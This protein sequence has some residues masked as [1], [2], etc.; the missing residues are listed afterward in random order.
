M[1]TR[2]SVRIGLS[3]QVVSRYN[4]LTIRKS[5]RGLTPMQHLQSIEL[6]VETD[7]LVGTRKNPE[8]EL[9]GI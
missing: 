9:E 2:P 8:N 7:Y 5:L 3:E 6:Q 1:A 4:N